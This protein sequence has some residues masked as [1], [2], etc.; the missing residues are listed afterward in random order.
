MGE[1]CA[2][3]GTADER[4]LCDCI[5]LLWVLGVQLRISGLIMARAV[6]SR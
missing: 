1:R 4:H 6:T 5:D 2:D 3:P